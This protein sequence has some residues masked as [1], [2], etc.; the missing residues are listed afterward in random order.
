MARDRKDRSASWFMAHHGGSL[1]RLVP[2]S[3]FLG[4]QATQTVLGFPKQVPDGLL[5]VTFPDK[6]T[7]DPFLRGLGSVHFFGKLELTP[8]APTQPA[9]GFFVARG[10]PIRRTSTWKPCQ[11]SLRKATSAFRTDLT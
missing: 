4:W 10:V 7:P 6:A 5:D 3:N 9:R 11:P 1:L 2:I 8:L